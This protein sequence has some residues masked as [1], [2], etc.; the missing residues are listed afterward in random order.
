ME[1]IQHNDENFWSLWYQLSDSVDYTHPVYSDIGISFY[2]E[3][4][5]KKEKVQNRSFLII[6][7]DTPV[8]GAIMSLDGIDKKVNLSGFGRGIIY[9][10]NNLGNI[11]GIKGARKVF[12]KE[13]DKIIEID[14]VSSIFFRDYTSVDGNL[15]IL[16]RR[17][18]DMGG[19][20]DIHYIQ[21][22]DLKD[23]LE[24]IH[25]GLSK[26]CRNSINWGMKNININIYDH[27]NISIDNIYELRNLHIQESGRETRS[28]E[29]W[30]IMYEMIL[31]N[32]AFIIEGRIDDDIATSSLFYLNK[33]VCLYAVS[34]SQRSLFD[35]PIGHVILWEAIRVAKELNCK[36]FDSGGL[37]YNSYNHFIS[38]KQF[39]INRYKKNFGGE[40]KAQLSIKWEK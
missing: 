14:S 13:F 15:S 16:A 11:D 6:N 25:S 29:S 5:F 31:S 7:N 36:Y 9:I 30:E 17:L 27:K 20:G 10:E 34:A 4:F 28:K 8:L 23:S 40:T 2:K 35:K 37:E 18:L 3:Y 22:I 24:S 1:I 12:K 38:P 39:N 26:S 32:K 19:I 21:L 33:R